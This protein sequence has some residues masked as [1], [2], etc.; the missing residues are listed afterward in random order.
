MKNIIFLLAITIAA[1]TAKAQ[2]PAPDPDTLQNPVKQIDPEVKQEPAD[3]HYVDEMTRITADELP[4]IVRDSLKSLEP[5][6]W[7]KSVIYK[8]KNEDMYT[9]EVRDGGQE[10]TY[11]FSKDGKRLKNLDQQKKK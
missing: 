11:R 8:S 9:I 3:I 10:N 5:A 2:T 6:A 7:E 4:T 1:F